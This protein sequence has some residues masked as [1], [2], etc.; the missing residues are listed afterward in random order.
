[1][2]LGQTTGAAFLSVNLMSH[3]GDFLVCRLGFE[4]GLNWSTG[5]PSE[6]IVGF[7]CL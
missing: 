1:M 7:Y 5:R 6:E 4:F 2:I 3:N